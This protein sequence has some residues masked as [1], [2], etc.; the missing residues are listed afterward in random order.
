MVM[1]CSG[2]NSNANAAASLGQ[3]GNNCNLQY[4]AKLTH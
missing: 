4:L 2:R 3:C 1:F